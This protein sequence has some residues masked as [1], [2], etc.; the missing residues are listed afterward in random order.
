MSSFNQR[1]AVRRPWWQV[2]MTSVG[3]ASLLASCS[4][5]V[6]KA[7]GI[8]TPTVGATTW[9]LTWHD[10]FNGQGAPAQWTPQTG[11]YGFGDHQLEWNSTTNATL[12]GHG[13]LDI[14]ATK[15]GGG[16]QCWYGPCKYQSAKLVTYKI[17]AQ[18]YGRFEARIKLPPGK[19]LWPAFWLEGVK[20][21]GEIDII[22]VNNANPYL[23]KGYAHG[24]KFKF[25]AQKVLTEK[26]AS[27]YHV[28]GVDWTR[29]GI[30]WTFDGQ[31]F[32]HLNSFRGW[33]FSHPFFIIL[34][35]A[36]GGV[37]PGPPTAST[38]F[39]AHLL[40][41]WIRVYERVS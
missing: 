35:L 5:L 19:G 11:G 24:L 27:A 41:D 9:K 34:D 8:T 14:A 20:S 25:T 37:W 32:G 1:R 18:A 39:P 2:A 31:P 10:E 36:V 33:P 3:L 16:H 30:T 12:N 17:F 28:Y 21:G 4:L 15:G 26:P 6:G 7:S 38:P 29:K 22:E 23:I 40:V 13:V